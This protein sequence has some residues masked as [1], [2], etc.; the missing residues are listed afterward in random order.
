MKRILI[1][2]LAVASIF[3][4]GACDNQALQSSSGLSQ[5]KVSVKAGPD[6]MSTEQR[7]IKHRV[8]L[9]NQPGS[10][11]HLYVIAPE[12]GQTIL[13]STVQGK[14]TSSGKRVTPNNFYIIGE[15]TQGFIFDFNGKKAVTT[16]PLGDDGTYGSSD[17]YIYWWDVRGVYHQHYVN[18]GQI[19]HVSD[20]PIAVKSVIINI[21]QT[22]KP[23]SN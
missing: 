12:S 9:E 2:I 14:V 10:I 23:V 4:L 1:T 3:A 16:E 17:P 11:K 13:Y 6:G 5:A 21:E 19:I 22:A 15:S 7:N 20:Q 8:E 18:G